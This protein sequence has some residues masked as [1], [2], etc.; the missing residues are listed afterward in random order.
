[1]SSTGQ[2]TSSPSTVQSIVDAL[3]DYTKVTGIDLSNNPFAAAIEHSNSP[4]A[5]LELLQ[6]REKAFKEYRDVNE[7]VNRRLINCLRPAVEVIYPFSGILGEAAS[8]VS[9]AFHPGDPFNVTSLGPVSTNKSFV[10]WHRYSPCCTS[11]ECVF[12][13]VPVINEC[14][15]LLVESRR[16]MTAFSTCSSAWGASSSVWRFIR[17]FHQIR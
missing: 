5:I 15:R 10:C 6:E 12:Q 14:A 2:A 17:R 13:P 7:S 16:V 9:Y 1:M 4:E 3:A 11:L 8:L